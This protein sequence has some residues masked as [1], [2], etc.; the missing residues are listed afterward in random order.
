MHC[1]VNQPDSV[2]NDGVFCTTNFINLLDFRHP[3]GVGTKIPISNLDVKSVFSIGDIV[4]LGTKRASSPQ[5]QQF[6]FRRQNSTPVATYHM[7][8]SNNL[9]FSDNITQVWGDSHFVMAVSSLGFGRFLTGEFN[10]TRNGV[11]LGPNDMF[12]PSFDFASSRILII[13][14]DRPAQWMNII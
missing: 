13:S 10:K 12:C 7:P 2:R 3:T 1:R 6:S 14:R 8:E 4:L 5:V 11:V 9:L